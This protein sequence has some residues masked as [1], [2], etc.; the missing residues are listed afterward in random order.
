MSGLSQTYLSEIAAAHEPGSATEHT[1]RPALKNLLE[2]FSAGTTALSE[3]K[4]IK[5]GAP[6]YIISRGAVP[7]GFI[8]AKDTGVPLEETEN[9]DVHTKNICNFR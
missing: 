6:D 4:R 3:P 8:E 7:V 9:S 2:A 5:C 1:Y